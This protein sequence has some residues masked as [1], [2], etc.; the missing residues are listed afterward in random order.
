MG[1]HD[2]NYNKSKRQIRSSLSGRV[3]NN[4]EVIEVN[5]AI[6]YVKQ[7]GYIVKKPFEEDNILEFIDAFMIKSIKGAPNNEQQIQN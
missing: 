2:K 5:E 6:E 4:Q 1:K 3:I 7:L